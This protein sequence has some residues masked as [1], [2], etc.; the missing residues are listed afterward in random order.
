MR[1][2]FEG[3]TQCRKVDMRDGPFFYLKLR[4]S[5]FVVYSWKA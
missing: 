3:L 4:G 1:M 2:I 5:G